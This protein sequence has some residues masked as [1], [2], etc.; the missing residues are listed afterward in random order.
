LT[1]GEARQLLD[2]LCA[3]LPKKDKSEP[4]APIF[5]LK[6]ETEVEL[7]A[8]VYL[9]SSLPPS[10]RTAE[11]RSSWR[12]EKKAK[13]DAAFQAYRALHE[14]GLVT[15]LLLPS[16]LPKEQDAPDEGDEVEKRDSLYDV[17]K[18]YDPWPIV[19]EL[20]ESPGSCRVY[21]HR[22]Q[23]EAPDFF[24]PS[25]L[26]L[27]PVRLSKLAFS[28]FTTKTSCLSVTI[29]A[30]SERQGFPL[31]LAQ[32][33]TFLL[34]TTMLR[35]RLTGLRKEQ[36]PSLF[37]P[38]IQQSSLRTWY[39]AASTSTPMTD[40]DQ[41]NGASCK[42]YLVQSRKRNVPFLWQPDT[43]HRD[44]HQAYDVQA[45]DY[46]TSICVTVLPRTLDYLQ[47]VNM[48][49][50]DRESVIDLPV[51]ECSVL[52]LPS[53]YGCFV[54]LIP[55]IMHMLEVSLR[56]AAACE[57][58]LTA[59][60]LN[61]LDLVSQ[62]LTLPGASHTRNYER[63][64]FI[65][66]TILKFYAALHVFADYPIYP[67]HHLTRSRG[68]IINN[69]RL[70]RATRLLGLDQYLSRQSFAAKEW[71]AGVSGLRP[72]VKQPPKELSSKTLADVV[73]A[74]IGVANVS[75][76]EEGVSEEKVLATLKLFIDEV[77]W[78]PLSEIVAQIQPP[79]QAPEDAADLLAPVE[80]MIGYSFQN[81]GLLAEAL[82]QS[83][84][85]SDLR[86]TYDRLEF[87]VS[88]LSLQFYA[89]YSTHLGTCENLSVSSGTSPLSRSFG[90]F[91]LY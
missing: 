63:L 19:M 51:D 24:Y 57:G 79:E 90:S 35:R 88:Y 84:L 70:Q 56:S 4:S 10:L 55:S 7:R 76:L 74:V 3:K 40:F 26:L 48:P 59:I 60:G 52:G 18:Q 14:A 17:Q 29:G 15:D 2:R 33:I 20:W 30:G 31:D 23:L 16:E 78:R 67:A 91:P 64:E 38:D 66:D 41:T 47:Q 80:V 37:V 46:P 36:L 58:P 65:G 68:R 87:L 42:S 22:L 53:E 75:G 28:L 39:E 89:L 61:N 86:S 1:F 81:R 44:G 43:V 9:P 72:S 11:S 5:I 32:D 8:K 62:A 45:R 34:L 27:L 13:Q 50:F 6:A 49:D 71:T 21:A 25:M 54:L 85:G 77:A 69:A 12:T 83:S 82:T 73:E